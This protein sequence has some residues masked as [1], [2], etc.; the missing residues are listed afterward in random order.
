[1]ALID[2]DRRTV[3]SLRGEAGRAVIHY[4]RRLK[5]FGVRVS[6]QG[7]ISYFVEFRPGAGGR[8]VAKR[9]I[10]LGRDAP[11]FRADHARASAETHLARVRLGEDPAAERHARRNAPTVY[12]VVQGYIDGRVA[13]LR[14]PTTHTLYSGYLRIH[15]GP[16]IGARPAHLLSRKDVTDLHRTI[17]RKHPVTANRV[18]V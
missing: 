11:H 2:I 1:M 5:G 9:R 7:L 8:R 6:P 13:R 14:K 3:S 12:E 10:V 15:I 18:V 16:V 17:G 4:D